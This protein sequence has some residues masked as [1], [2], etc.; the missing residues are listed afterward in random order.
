[1]ELVC[2]DALPGWG[3]VP[4]VWRGDDVEWAV[5]DVCGDGGEAEESLAIGLFDEPRLFRK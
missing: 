1:M 4:V 5:S 3:V 2:P